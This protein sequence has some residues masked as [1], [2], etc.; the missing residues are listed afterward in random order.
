MRDIQDGIDEAEEGDTVLVL[1]GTYA[2]PDDQNL[3]FKY[4]NNNSPKHIVLMSRG[5]PDS[6][7]IDCEGSES[8]F[9]IM[10]GTDTTLQIVGFK[11]INGWAQNGFMGSG[12][13]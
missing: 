8:A 7:I 5:G 6:T 2:R 9:V 13:F 3:E 11:I 1:P 12:Y 10:S 4:H